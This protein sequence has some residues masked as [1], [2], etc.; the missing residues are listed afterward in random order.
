MLVNLLPLSGGTLSGQLILTRANNTADNNGQIFLN[1]A[2]GNRIDFIG[3]GVEAPTFTTRSLG[4]KLVFYPSVTI[5]SVDYGMGI[6]SSSLW[7]SI[8][9][10]ASSYFFRWYAGTTNIMNLRGDGELLL[11]QTNDGAGL[12]FLMEVKLQKVG[13]GI[14]IRKDQ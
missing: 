2:T 5:N 8:P 7:Q 11:N 13:G 12:F 4:T 9:Q 3:I 6:Q 10:N 1:G 14:V